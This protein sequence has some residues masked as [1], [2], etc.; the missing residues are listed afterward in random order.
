MR[1]SC[2]AS[3]GVG[4]GCFREGLLPPLLRLLPVDDVRNR[5]RM[6]RDVGDVAGD[7]VVCLLLLL[8]LLMLSSAKA[9]PLVA[10]VGVPDDELLLVP[11]LLERFLLH[12]PI[13]A[14]VSE[15]VSE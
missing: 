9:R 11:E 12:R 1:I 10:S 13:V 6:K 15:R 14:V 7:D 5:V 4:L 2:C 3:A 8:L